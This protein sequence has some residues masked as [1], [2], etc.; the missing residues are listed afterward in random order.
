MSFPK[1]FVWGAASASY[2]IEGA[3]DEDG[4]GP[5][6][7]DEFCRREGAVKN[8]DTG[9]IACDA[10]HR[11][12]ED[13]E[14]LCGMGLRAYRFSISWPRILPEG[15]GEVNPAGFLYYDRLV[16]LLLEKGIEP[17]ITLYHWDLPLAL[18]KEGGWLVRSTA[19]AFAEYASIVAKHFDGR[20][21]NYFT[22]NEPQCTMLLGYSAGQHAPGKTLPLGECLSGIHNLLLAHGYAVRAIRSNS[23]APVSIGIASTGKLCY[24]EKDTAENID[25]ARRAS[26][27][28]ET[29]DVLF[30]H[31]WVLDPVLFGHYPSE[32]DPELAAF[33]S[34]IP[35]ADM[36][37]ICQPIDYLGL[38]IYN[39]TEVDGEGRKTKKYP[40]FP[41]TSLKWAVTPEVLRYGPRWISERY[42]LP[43]YIT[44]NGQACND[45]IFLDGKIHDPDR[46]DY[47]ARYLGEL[48]KS[49]DE[50]VPVRGYFHWSLTDNF[51]WHNGY[52]ERFGLVYVDFRTCERIRKDSSYWFADFA[53]A[54]R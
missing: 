20:V 13:V 18:E 5:S 41:R 8:G 30:S 40:G 6:I 3:C 44:E 29:G 45:R 14:L 22:L 32:A 16:D 38:N 25:A 21:K 35:P 7:W 17:Y 26:F 4:K 28:A 39:G 9:D 36:D 31:S 34:R 23:S 48:E 11:F 53:A 12:A 47:L 52:D 54:N 33:A 27:Y 37:A 51:E 43:V 1:G 24:P 50:G 42:R 2:Q 19:E 10:Y 15:R 46:I 49:I